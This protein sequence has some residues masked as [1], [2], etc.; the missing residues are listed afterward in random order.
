[1]T[2]E[3]NQS[4]PSES[5]N[6]LHT[7]M[8]R[9]QKWIDQVHSWKQ[10]MCEAIDQVKVGMFLSTEDAAP[11]GPGQFESEIR[12]HYELENAQNCGK[13]KEF[14]FQA[15]EAR[16]QLISGTERD[17]RQ[18][19]NQLGISPDRVLEINEKT[20]PPLLE[21]DNQIKDD[22]GLL[23]ATL[24][25]GTSP[26]AVSIENILSLH[27]AHDWVSQERFNIQ[28]AFT[29]QTKKLQEDLDT[30]LDQQ[31][32][33]FREERQKVLNSTRE[34]M[35]HEVESF[36][37]PYRRKTS[38]HFQSSAKRGMLLQTAPPLCVDPSEDG[39]DRLQRQSSIKGG[40]VRTGPRRIRSDVDETQERLDE[41]ERR[42]RIRKEVGW[43]LAADL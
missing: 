22:P 32:T 4:N 42:L 15:S 43:F 29:N 38:S 31:E 25:R 10:D 8:Q 9:W 5:S 18:F 7:T 37:K 1:M 12:Q 28:E 39:K 2:S 26:T 40:R 21:G 14:H 30:F 34:Q 33:E 24:T 11:F 16:R 6:T 19:C 13:W 23:A 20:E 35:Q 36:P 41:L 3:H 27:L 17:F